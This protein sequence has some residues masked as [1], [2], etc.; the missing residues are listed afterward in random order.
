[1]KSSAEILKMTSP[2]ELFS[3]PHTV[4]AEYKE[5]TKVWH[6]DLNSNSKEAQD[7]MS[8][9]NKLYNQ[10]QEMI[11]SGK[12]INVD[13]FSVRC[14]DGKIREIHYQIARPFELGTMYVA[15]RVVVY[16]VDGKHKNLFNNAR[17]RI[18]SFR[19]AN[20]RMEDEVL[21]YL[22]TVIDTF[23]TNDNTLGMVV[24]KTPDLLLL[25]DVLNWYGGKI[26]D[27]HVAW[28]QS[29]LHNLLCYLDYAKLSHNAISPDTYFISPEYHSGALLGGW[30]Y[31]VPQN[32]KMISVPV[33]TFQVL[34]PDVKRGKIGSIKTDMELIRALGR[35]L[36]GDRNGTRLLETKAAPEPIVNW[37]RGTASD[38]A[39][40]DYKMWSK[41]L[42]NSYG[43]R[44]FVK[45]DLT[46]DMLY[47]R[48][49]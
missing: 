15:N 1:M 8:H 7:V 37:L 6:P 44:C 24:T 35:E 27:R 13:M 38:N 4:K 49:R 12:W 20:K 31:S 22:P 34:P 3:N 10:A 45:M 2:G 19:F 28:I 41:V 42:D 21:K 23:E 11:E 36:L 17:E 40:N 25:R 32:S 43:S 16:I 29:S 48:G 46:A 30:W 33:A 26:P 18:A 39:L 5:L 9:I 47:K 14:K